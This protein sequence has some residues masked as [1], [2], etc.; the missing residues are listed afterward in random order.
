MPNVHIT[1]TDPLGLASAGVINLKS[2][3][4]TTP[5]SYVEILLSSG[6]YSAAAVK[7][8]KPLEQ[9]DIVY[10]LLDT[11]SLTVAF[12]VAV[13][14]NFLIS[15]F[16]CAS[17]PE[18]Y[19]EVTISCIKPS[20]ATLIKA[21]SGSVSLTAVG[22]FG[23]VNK[24]DATAASAMISSQCSVSM[25]SLDAMDETTGDFLL[26][27]IYRFGFKQE[28]QVEAYGAITIP[29]GAHAKPNEPSTPKQTA[30]GWQTYQGS[31]WKYLDPT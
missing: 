13:N 11:A 27:G 21:Y 1:A 7:K 22:G 23:I 28:C 10:E 24:W 15:S 16:S 14:T 30:E 18:K 12:G 9:F 31:W 2:I 8:I 5:R 20:S 4:P 19:P 26:G 29:A 17:G 6:K 3:T 25:Q